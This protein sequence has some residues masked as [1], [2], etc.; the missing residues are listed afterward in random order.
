MNEKSLRQIFYDHEGPLI[1][2]WDHYFEI[3]DRYFSQYRNQKINILEIGVS[4]GGSLQLWK[5]YFGDQVNIYAIDIN[6][7][8]KQFEE[9]SVRI[10]IGSQSDRTFLKDVAGQ[11]PDLDI[12]IDDGGHTMEQQ[13]VSFEL[14]YP[15]V[16]EGGIYI[17]EDTHTSYWYEF[18]GGLRKRT[19]FIE[20]SKDIIDSLYEHHI[21]EKNRIKVTDN[22]R[23][24]NSV[25]FYDSMVIFE[26]LLRQDVFHIRKGSKSIEAYRPTELK[27][28]TVLMK[29][30]QKIFGKKKHSFDLNNRG[31]L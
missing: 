21:H 24:I 17:V 26:K 13:K 10:F 7:A 11:I 28:K 27:K 2:K 12:V 18:H 20:Y 15:K 9:E 14:L 6:P 1:H 16:K 22:I 23:H 5:K 31:K 25:H 19:S 4:Q 29:I 8:C 30:K 3:Y